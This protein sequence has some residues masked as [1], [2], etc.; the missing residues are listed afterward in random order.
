MGFDEDLAK[1]TFALVLM[2]Y[3]KIKGSDPIMDGD[4]ASYRADL[5]LDPA[6]VNEIHR[7]VITAAVKR[8]AP[9]TPI[10]QVRKM[11]VVRHLPKTKALTDAQRIIQKYRNRSL[12][13]QPRPMYVLIYDYNGKPVGVSKL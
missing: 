13:G 11:E 10:K 1:A 2:G 3:E 5:P 6:F 8:D 4:S 9:V 12:K 7:T